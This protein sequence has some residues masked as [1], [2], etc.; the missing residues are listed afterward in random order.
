MQAGE[1]GR[2]GSGGGDDIDEFLWVD[3]LLIDSGARSAHALDGRS[4]HDLI[5]RRKR[6]RER[7]K[8]VQKAR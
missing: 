3:G 1:V 2:I 8:D 5:S 7:E 4:S 6:E